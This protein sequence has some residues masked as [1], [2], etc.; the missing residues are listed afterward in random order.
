MPAFGGTP[1]SVATKAELDSALATIPNLGIIEITADLPS[2]AGTTTLPNR[3]AGF[4]A[5][6]RGS[7]H[8]G[9]PA[10]SSNYLTAT[11]ATNRVD[12]TTHAASL[13]QIQQT[14]TNTP[15]F[16]TANAAEG[17]WI[18]GLDLLSATGVN[19]QQ[20][21]VLLD[22]NTSHTSETDLPRYIT[23]DRCVI[24]TPTVTTNNVRRGVQTDG[25]Y[26]LVAHCDIDIAFDPGGSDSQAIGGFKGSRYGLVFNCHLRGGSECII[27]GGAS[28]SIPNYD[29][30]DWAFIRNH[31]TKDTSWSADLRFK[32]WFEMKHGVRF[33]VWGNEFENAYGGPGA[34]QFY[35]FITNV[36][37]P[38]GD[39]AWAK[40][41]DVVFWFNYCRNMQAGTYDFA[42]R[43]SNPN[44]NAGTRNIEF[45]HNAAPD[46]VLPVGGNATGIIISNSGVAA[47]GMTIHHNLLDH[48]H[49]LILFAN[50]NSFGASS[51]GHFSD[52]IN[53]NSFSFGPIFAGGGTDDS[54]TLNAIYSGGYECRNN[55]KLTGGA[56]WDATLLGFGNNSFASEAAIFTDPT[57]GDFTVKTGHAA[58]NTGLFGEDPGPY[59]TG[60]NAAIAGVR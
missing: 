7:N 19:Q 15:I 51:N 30:A 47:D 38:N 34:A 60:L 54:T 57:N 43:G 11:K 39:N 16:R 48:T 27:S 58:E 59:W 36:A 28:V 18:T 23:I 6:I 41:E 22:G 40:V 3:G 5:L 32:N 52:N 13:R 17:W 53:R 9:L 45:A 37:N 24:R 1:V 56:N 20:A 4:R 46:M 10:Y 33:Y 29:P 21:L 2:W 55:W 31:V 44:P 8:A 26:T 49:S 25:L 50:P 42:M 12:R 35:A 14:S